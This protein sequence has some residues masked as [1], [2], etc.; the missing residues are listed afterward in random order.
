MYQALDQFNVCDFFLCHET[1]EDLWLKEGYPT[2]LFYQGILK[3]AVG[4]Y[5]RNKGNPRGARAKLRE[6]ID[7]LEP[8]TPQ[9]MGVEVGKLRTDAGQCLESLANGEKPP[10]VT[11]SRP[12]VS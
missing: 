10:S 3:V 11:F 4:L 2:R 1:L 6:G 9:F 7:L 5:H 12:S 8:F